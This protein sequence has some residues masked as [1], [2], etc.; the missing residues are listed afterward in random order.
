MVTRLTGEGPCCCS[1]PRR[2]R[3]TTPDL[4]GG[5]RRGP[6]L[7]VLPQPHQLRPPLEPYEGGAA[8]RPSGPDRAAARGSHLQL[9]GPEESEDHVL[10]VL[11]RM[12]PCI[13]RDHR[14][15][16]PDP[17][18]CR[19][20]LET[21][22]SLPPSEGSAALKNLDAILEARIRGAR[23]A[24]RK[25]ADLIMDTKSYRKDEVDEL[26]AGAVRSTPGRSRRFALGALYELGATI[27][28]DAEVPRS[29]RASPERA[30]REQY[31]QFGSERDGP[32][33]SPSI[34]RSLAIMRI[35]S[36]SRS[37]TR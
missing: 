3:T 19:D 18:D 35:L 14:R 6:Q 26:S 20:R 32:D 8:H 25:L 33:E 22:F 13:R 4:N 27:S 28:D 23:E 15:P 34:R 11:A 24:E 21:T 31:P 2:S 30:I 16:R 29:L 7:P 10:D 5:G 36:S 9:L 1:L 17:R 37:V 12:D